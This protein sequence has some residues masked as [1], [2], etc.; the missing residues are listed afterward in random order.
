MMYWSN[1][2]IWKQTLRGESLLLTMRS[3]QSQSSYEQNKLA[4]IL[5]FNL[6]SPAK[7]L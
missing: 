5:Y 3:L 4:S 1:I 6:H 7:R 2:Y